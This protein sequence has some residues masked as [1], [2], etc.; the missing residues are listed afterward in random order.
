MPNQTD[1]KYYTVDIGCS[2]DMGL[3]SKHY[4]MQEIF[5]FFNVH[6]KLKS[7]FATKYPTR[8]DP[9]LYMLFRDKN[10]IRV[11][12]MP[13]KYSNIL[14]PNTDSIEDRIGAIKYLQ[15]Y[16]EVHINFS[17]VIFE[18]DWRQQ[19]LHLFELLWEQDIDVPCEVIML[20]YNEKQAL[21]QDDSVIKHL[22]YKPHLQEEK[23]S[24]YAPGNLRY[25]GPLKT[26]MVEQ[27]KEMHNK[28]FKSPIRYIF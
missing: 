5:D 7:T 28:Y 20:T 18:R 14:E 1:D 26:Q 2:T 21:K 10:R 22:L 27:F 3:H 9:N 6:P 11:S 8:F 17:P 13:E 24:Q 16:M 23:D 19:Y 15:Q 25:H 4:K 12:L